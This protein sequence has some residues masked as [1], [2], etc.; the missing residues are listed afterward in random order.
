MWLKDRT[1]GEKIHEVLVKCPWVC[2]I[3][4]NADRS[5][6]YA[7]GNKDEICCSQSWYQFFLF[8]PGG[9]F[10][11]IFTAFFRVKPVWL[12]LRRQFKTSISGILLRSH[13]EGF[14]V[15]HLGNG[16]S[17]YERALKPLLLTS[18]VTSC[19][20]GDSPV[21]GLSNFIR[22]TSVVC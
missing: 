8:E 13:S 7:S 21:S 3:A 11:L 4:V 17:R 20:N 15:R 22:W 5:A 6:S 2:E 12:N 19:P 1:H 10:L 9:Y 16:S 14:Y 18:S